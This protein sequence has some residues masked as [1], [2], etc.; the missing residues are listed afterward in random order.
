MGAS[1]PQHLRFNPFCL[2]LRDSSISHGCGLESNIHSTAALLSTRDLAHIPSRFRSQT[3]CCERPPRLLTRTR[4]QF[5]DRIPRRVRANWRAAAWLRIPDFSSSSSPI[6]LSTCHRSRGTTI[7]WYH[8]HEPNFSAT[9]ALPAGLDLP[10][11]RLTA[12]VFRRVLRS[13]PCLQWRAAHHF[14]A[15]VR[16]VINAVP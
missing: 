4:P 13:A 3:L 10:R 1:P 6:S 12:R 16:Y 11:T 15:P 2:L 5:P 7:T 8:G 9:G 14:F